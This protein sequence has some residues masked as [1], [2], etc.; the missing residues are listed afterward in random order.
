MTIETAKVPE[1]E[2][3][4]IMELDRDYF[5]DPKAAQDFA[6]STFRVFQRLEKE[7][8]QCETDPR[9]MRSQAGLLSSRLLPILAP[10]WSRWLSDPI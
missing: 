1:G 8:N 9:T 7:R 2:L 10:S 6:T 4:R 5:V 3:S